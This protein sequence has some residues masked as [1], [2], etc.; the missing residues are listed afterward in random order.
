[1]P[2]RRM[3]QIQIMDLDEVEECNDD[4]T[5]PGDCHGKSRI[6]NQYDVQINRP[7]DVQSVLTA[8]GMAF[9]PEMIRAMSEGNADEA[10]EVLQGIKAVVG[11]DLEDPDNETAAEAVGDL[12]SLALMHG[13]ALKGA[14]AATKEFYRQNAAA[15]V[16]EAERLVTGKA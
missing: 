13:T 10:W 11:W 6:L 1:M 2:K 8:V 16:A 4:E 7:Q 12:A 5:C 15:A 9:I 3:L 14:A